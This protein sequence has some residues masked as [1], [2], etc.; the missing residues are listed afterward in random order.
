M[1]KLK[2]FKPEEVQLKPGIFLDRFRLNRE[3]VL[4]SV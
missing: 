2:R 1:E 3:Y 4:S